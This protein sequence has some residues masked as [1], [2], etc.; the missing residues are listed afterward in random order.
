[1]VIHSKA[2]HIRNT[3]NKQIVP[4]TYSRRENDFPKFFAGYGFRVLSHSKS[5]LP[6]RPVQLTTEYMECTENREFPENHFRTFRVFR[7]F[8]ITPNLKG[9]SKIDLTAEILYD[10]HRKET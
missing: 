3:K 9:G 5:K 10:T 2:F 6:D 8:G 4:R 1:M 7:D